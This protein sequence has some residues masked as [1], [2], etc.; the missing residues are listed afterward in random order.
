MTRKNNE[1]LAQVEIII[2]GLVLAALIVG[3]VVGG[4]YWLACRFSPGVLRWVAVVSWLLW[5][6]S[7]AGTWRVATNSAREHLKGFDR[8][9]DGAERTIQTVGRGLAATASLA[10]VAARPPS[11]PARDDSDLL[12]RPGSMRILEAG[13]SNGDVLEL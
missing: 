5:A 10:R 8:G 4:L 13:S 11:L 6:G 7:V 9:L 3:L 2:G 12:P 1:R